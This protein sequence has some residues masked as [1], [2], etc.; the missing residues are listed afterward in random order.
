MIEGSLRI[1]LIYVWNLDN[2]KSFSFLVK[3]SILEKQT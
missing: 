2:F 3:V 1:I